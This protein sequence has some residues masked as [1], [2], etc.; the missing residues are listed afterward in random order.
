MQRLQTIVSPRLTTFLLGSAALALVAS[1]IL[2]PD[3]AFKASLQGLQLWWKLVFPALLPF[4]ILTELMRGMGV[5]HGLGILLEPFLRLLFRLPGIGGWVLTLSFT[6]GLP[7]GAAAIGA[8]RKDGTVTREEGER[9]LSVSHVQNPVFLISIVGVSFLHS[10]TS[11]L[12]LAIIHYASAFLLAMYHRLRFSPRNSS[13]TSFDFWKGRYLSRSLDALHEAKT[14]D[15][16]TFGKLLGDAV[17]SSIQQLFIVGGCMMMFSVLLHVLFLSGWV[18]YVASAASALGFGR[19]DSVKLISGLLAGFLEPHLGA[20][21]MAQEASSGSSSILYALVSMMLAWGGLS[22]HAQVKS[23]TFSTDLRFSRFLQ[24]RFLHGGI[25]FIFTLLAWNPLNVWLN[26]ETPVI[27]NH[28]VLS[29]ISSSWSIEKGNL[30]PLVSPLMLQ[31]GTVLLLM[32]ILSVF[33]VFL[34]YRRKKNP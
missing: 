27:S 7:A 26:D 16:R 23:M 19:E 14:K 9:L 1:I 13:E 15:G 12:A 29:A 3:T 6:A 33:T 5:M 20:Y 28:S 22:T 8:L 18:T 30:W 4:L 25:A 24:S 21:M 34:F 2:F 31:F 10:P 32:L 17:T 11:G